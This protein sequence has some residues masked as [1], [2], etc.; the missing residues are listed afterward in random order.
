MYNKTINKL[1]TSIN[2]IYKNSKREE[3]TLGIARKYGLSSAFKQFQ[4]GQVSLEWNEL[5]SKDC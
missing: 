2:K 4:K 3:I 5:F 1:I